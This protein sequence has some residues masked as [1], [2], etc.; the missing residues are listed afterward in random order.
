MPELAIHPPVH[1][2]LHPDEPIRSVEAAIKVIERH[3]ETQPDPPSI[4]LVARLRA[5]DTPDRSAEAS[6]AFARWARERG[7]LLSP[8]TETRP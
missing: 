4:E 6:L 3:L 7:L 8:P 2:T 1:L 5:I